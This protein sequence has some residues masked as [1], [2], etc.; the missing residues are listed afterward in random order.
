M[1]ID[2]DNKTKY[3]MHGNVW[4]WCQ[5]YWHG[6]YKG[7]PLD[8]TP[9]LDSD[10]NTNRVLRG[11]SW[12]NEPSLCRSGCRFFDDAYSRSKNVG[13]RIARSI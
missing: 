4:E 3:E 10:A 7:A 6:T 5:D 9:W 12:Q 2:F 1:I 13:F 8:G 11:G